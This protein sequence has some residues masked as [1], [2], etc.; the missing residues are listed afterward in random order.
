MYQQQLA[1]ALEG[2]HVAIRGALEHLGTQHASPK[3]LMLSPCPLAPRSSSHHKCFTLS[4][5]LLVKFPFSLAYLGTFELVYFLG[6]D[7]LL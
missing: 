2:F 1:V 7:V 5:L 4:P 6:R 3:G